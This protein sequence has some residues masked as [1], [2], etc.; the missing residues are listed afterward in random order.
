L[1]S[2]PFLES[3]LGEQ[4]VREGPDR[5]L[6]LLNREKA[7]ELGKTEVLARVFVGPKAGFRRVN[8]LSTRW[9]YY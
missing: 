6:K 9:S 7:S 4:L 1:F 8:H 5:A 2:N 3:D